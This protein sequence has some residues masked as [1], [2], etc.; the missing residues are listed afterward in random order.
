MINRLLTFTLLS[1]AAA[2]QATTYTTLTLPV[3]NA[4]IRTFSDGGVYAPLFPS[5]QTWADV[6][7]QF[8]PSP[9]GNTAFIEG[10]LNIPVGVFG[11][12]SAYT[13]INS[14][15]GAFGANNGSVEFFGS[16]GYYKVDLIQG[17]N[18]RDHFDYVFNNIIDG[19]NAV[20]AFYVG[21]GRARLDEQIYNLPAVFA[22]QTLVSMRFTGLNQ[23]VSG[24]PFIVAATVAV[25]TPVPEPASAL[26]LLSG[27]VA[28]LAWRRRAGA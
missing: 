7:F 6:P 15:F 16:T 28:L 2:A 26:L 11:V 4:D 1:A 3:L 9:A 21:P 8:V 18:I 20:P 19:I 22:S 23:G 24:N 12:T 25:A 17:V 27:G 13:I 14:G 10:V 5:T